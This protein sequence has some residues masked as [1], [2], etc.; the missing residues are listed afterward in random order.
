MCIAGKDHL[1]VEIEKETIH[2]IEQQYSD[3]FI[4][5]A[6]KCSD[7]YVEAKYKFVP[8]D[9][10]EAYYN[11]Q[12][13]KV[14]EVYNNISQKNKIQIIDN[15]YNIILYNKKRRTGTSFSI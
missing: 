3:Y 7:K 6:Q 12:G 10:L 1:S 8:G 9:C 13:Q 11:E 2:K 4:V 14:T 5:D 15:N